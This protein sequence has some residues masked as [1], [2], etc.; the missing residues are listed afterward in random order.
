MICLGVLT[1]YRRVT[2]GGQTDR[3]ASCKSRVHRVVQVI[4]FF[5]F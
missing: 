1:E 4:R 3:Q 2:D 5:V